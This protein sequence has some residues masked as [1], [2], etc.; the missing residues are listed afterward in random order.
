[1]LYARA[2]A[3]RNCGRFTVVAS[4]FGSDYRTHTHVTSEAL[5][6]SLTRGATWKPHI[7]DLKTDAYDFTETYDIP[8]LPVWFLPGLF[9]AETGYRLPDDHFDT[10][11]FNVVNEAYPSTSKCYIFKKGYLE[12]K[13]RPHHVPT[14]G[15]IQAVKPNH[16]LVTYAFSQKR[17]IL[18]GF[19]EGQTY[20][21]GKK[22]T[23]FQIIELSPVEEGS[24]KNGVCGTNW[25]ELPPNYGGYFKQYQILAATMR[26]I[27]I[28][29]TT[30]D[31]VE[32]IEFRLGENNI[33]LPDFYWEIASKMFE[34]GQ[35]CS[36][37]DEAK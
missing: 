26:Y 19:A 34:C 1:M 10:S 24:W 32:Y 3:L 22:R 16:R 6:A 33:C 36:A 11:A 23:M 18:D 13:P 8:K 31:Y 27:I 28:R 21:L 35:V 25:L 5:Y 37:I 15:T 29:G 12:E 17:E 20:L 30:K 9:I 2:I 7:I 4:D 14:Y